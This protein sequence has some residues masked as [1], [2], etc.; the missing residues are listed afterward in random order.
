MKKVLSTL[1]VVFLI[2]IL[3]VACNP[4]PADSESD[5]PTIGF[6]YQSANA[7]AYHTVHYNECISYAKEI[8]IN[9]IMLDPGGDVAKQITQMEDLIEQKVDVLLLWPVD[10][11]AV[12]P[13]VKKAYDA[14][15]PVV[16]LVR[17]PEEAQ[18][19]V[20]AYVGED[21]VNMGRI[22]GQ[23]IVDHF[24]DSEKDIIKVVEIAVRSGSMVAQ[25]RGDGFREAI[26][27]TNIEIIESHSAESSRE[28]ATQIMEGYLSKYGDDIDVVYCQG[29]S[30]GIGALD[31][32][33]DAGKVGQFVTTGIGRNIESNE[34][35]VLGELTYDVLTSPL[36]LARAMMDA[37]LVIAT[38]GTVD[39]VVYVEAALV[40]LE[41]IDDFEVPTW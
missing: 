30:F 41:N 36:A 39:P 21:Q 5:E 31:A 34:R 8:G 11:N 29:D 1:L 33:K 24:A 6:V 20:T 3:L 2:S 35:M 7:D 12:V 19:Y 14:G 17:L 10:I 25:Q 26:E 16:T 23:A 40:S 18:P 15:I 9:L 38:G 27:G 22:L 28:T 4:A 37:A 32:I 13:V